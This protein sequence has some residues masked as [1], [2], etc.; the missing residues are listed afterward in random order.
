MAL[1]DAAADNDCVEH[2]LG[3]G[4]AGGVC[5]SADDA[6]AVT[7]AL[8]VA[9]MDAVEVDDSVPAAREAEGECVGV[10]ASV[11]ELDAVTVGDDE[12]HG[13]ELA[14]EEEESVAVGEALADAARD[15]AGV[16][17][18]DP[19]TVPLAA[20]D[21]VADPGRDGL[22]VDE[23]LRD[24]VPSAVAE[25]EA[26]VTTDLEI[27]GEPVARPLTL[28]GAEPVG[29]VEGDLEFGALRVSLLLPRGDLD[30]DGGAE[31]D[32]DSLGLCEIAGDE[33]ELLHATGVNEA[34]GDDE[35]RTERVSERIAEGEAL[36]CKLA[37]SADV[38]VARA[39][40][41]ARGVD[42]VVSVAN[43][44][45]ETLGLE[46]ALAQPLLL[47]E[48]SADSEALIDGVEDTLSAA[49]GEEELEDDGSTDADCVESG[50][51]VDDCDRPGVD[52]ALERREERGLRV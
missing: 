30:A 13:D 26:V 20:L 5:D 24:A 51:D 6:D 48:A 10:A 16:D 9:S 15:E 46:L 40:R 7:L 11:D 12:P 47:D 31:D 44:V 32:G 21:A 28:C 4:E 19:L 18:A 29:D 22:V 41:D 33:V 49:E 17:V 27:T 1:L 35:W 50:E 25:S 45:V 23:T 36:T 2:E 37:D 14:S 8:S 43:S 52:V 34:V 3:V 42:D 38:G 39:L